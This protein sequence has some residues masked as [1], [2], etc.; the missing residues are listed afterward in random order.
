MNK[1]LLLPISLSIVL[2]SCNPP[3]EDVV[4]MKYP[5][6]IK[7]DTVDTYFD[8]KVPDPYRWLENDTAKATGEWV[9]S[10]NEVTFGY[11]NAIP[12]RDQIKKRLEEVFN[13]ER[14]TA[15]F[16]EG[17]YFYFYKNDGLQNQSVLYRKKGIDGQPEI[18]LDPNGFSKDGTSALGGVSFTKDG[19]KAAYLVQE[20]GSD[21]RKAVVIKT[22][23]KAMI[24]DTLRDL[25]FT[26]ISWRGNEGFYYSSYDKPKGSELSAKT[27]YHKVFYHKLNTP[28]KSDVMIF[29]GEKTPRRYAFVGLTEDERFLTISAQ[30]S[31]TGNELYAQDLKDAKGKLVALVGNFNNDH[32]IVDNDG[33]RLIIQT[34]L[35]APNSKIVEV[36]FAKPAVENWKDIVPETEQAMQGVSTAG[37]KMLINYLKDASTLIKQFDYSGKLEREVE[38]PGIGSAGGFG[39]KVGD[40][41]VYYTFTSFT[42]PATIFKYDLASGKS[43]LYERPKVDFNSEDYETKQVFYTSKDGTKIPMFITHKKGI[44]LNGK[45]PTMLYA[46]GGFNVSL[47]PAFSTSRIVWLENGGVYAQPNLRG[48]GEYGEKWHLAGTKMNK[49]N[50]FDDFI[51]AGEYLITEK[52]TSSNYLAI[53]GGSNGGLL[54][55]ATMT[56]RPDLMKVALPAVGVMDML[57]YNKFTAGA[58][59]AYDYGTAEESKEMF[60]YL[61]T[62]SPV[63]AFKPGTAYPATLVTTAD[64]DDRV[65]PAHS[66]KFAATMQE[67]HVGD[68][69]VLIRIET[70][71]GHGSSNLSKAI[72]ETSDEFAFTWYSMG[73]TPPM[74]KK[75]M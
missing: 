22:A 59:W 45:N 55:G 40:K 28:Q 74:S 18:F 38:L 51:A 57:R 32:N 70:K 69:P 61:K 15:P 30:T 12:F 2:A 35:N 52:Y 13:Y 25:K 44:E 19:S 26:G 16:K 50:V 65:V 5:A 54:V 29:G 37:K 43:L 4:T 21:W 67:N 64:H 9:K 56:Q 24:G 46:Y 73:V 49:Q 66:Y 27:Q 39:G 41:E 8:T 6:T 62:Y 10:Q 68:N 60:E 33:S 1:K 53:Q 34:N 36:D 7:T 42:Y 58:G 47:T 3:K 14:L 11:L 31:T 75:S 71:S 72:E 48:G 23:D 20:G 17:D 63:H